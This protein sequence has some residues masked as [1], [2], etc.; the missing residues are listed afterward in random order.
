MFTIEK[1]I[2]IPQ[3]SGRGRDKSMLR[4]T[5]EKMEVGDSIVVKDVYRQQLHAM[6]KTL[7][8]G[9]KTRTICKGSGKIRFW[10]TK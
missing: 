4:L 2:P 8:I 7:G 3:D 6:S 10:R 1:N 9:Y 5:V